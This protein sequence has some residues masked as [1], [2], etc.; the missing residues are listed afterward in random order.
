MG[1]RLHV[2]VERC[3]TAVASRTEGGG[4]AA[5]MMGQGRGERAEQECEPPAALLTDSVLAIGHCNASASSRV[6]GGCGR[7]VRGPGKP[8]GWPAPRAWRR[9]TPGHVRSFHDAANKSVRRRSKPTFLKITHS[10]MQTM[11]HTVKGQPLAA[12]KAGARRVARAARVVNV[13]AEK[14]SAMQTRPL[15]AQVGARRVSADLAHHHSCMPRRR[16]LIDA[17]GRH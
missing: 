8:C 3:H 11:K 12:R 7:R 15:C 13:R 1:C 4:A 16:T 17:G 10:K 14:V 9:I 2:S 6:S 5:A